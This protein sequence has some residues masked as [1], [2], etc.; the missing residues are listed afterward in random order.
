FRP[1]RPAY[2]RRRSAGFREVSSEADNLFFDFIE[3][4]YAESEEHLAAARRGLLVVENAATEAAASLT[5][6]DDLLRSFHSLKGLSSMVGMMEIAQAAHLMEEY[7]REIRSL[8]SRPN[9]DGINALRSGVN[10]I[11]QV[12]AA[13][14]K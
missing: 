2:P 10:S 8:R 1:F 3:D 14:R 7:L 12:I 9:P 4:Y 5:A 13:R 6:I 11:E